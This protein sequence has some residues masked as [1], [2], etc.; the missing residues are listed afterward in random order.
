[1]FLNLNSVHICTHVWQTTRVVYQLYTIAAAFDLRCE[2][3][4]YIAIYTKNWLDTC[5]KEVYIAMNN[6]LTKNAC[7]PA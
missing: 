5:S 2:S 6:K 3:G 4:N 7:D 1:M